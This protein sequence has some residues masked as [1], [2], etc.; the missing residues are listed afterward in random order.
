M[1]LLRLCH[2]CIS[3]HALANVH[4]TSCYS[5][6]VCETLDQRAG[7]IESHM[8]PLPPVPEGDSSADAN[9]EGTAAE[10][11]C[12]WE[13]LPAEQRLGEVLDHLRHRHF[14][15]LYCGCQVAL[16]VSLLCCLFALIAISRRAYAYRCVVGACSM[17]TRK[18][19]NRAVPG[20]RRMIIEVAHR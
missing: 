14:Y 13:A 5:V 19:C 7:I 10:D 11:A 8:W 6:Q 15:C 12:G 20:K 1:V 9:A 2:G 3:Q 18:T 16:P 4:Y 17:A